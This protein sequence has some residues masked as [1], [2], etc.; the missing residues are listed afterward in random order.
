MRISKL[1]GW[2]LVIGAGIT[3]ALAHA[4]NESSGGGT[5]IICYTEAAEKAGWIPKSFVGELAPQAL[6]PAN[7]ESITQYDLYYA[8]KKE[9]GSKRLYKRKA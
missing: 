9:E 5:G 6:D 1:T 3:S 4:G 8:Q 7:I 2:A